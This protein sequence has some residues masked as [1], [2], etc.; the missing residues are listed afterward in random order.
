MTILPGTTEWP[1]NAVHV[2][3]SRI[4]SAVDADL[5]LFKR[6]LRTSDS[7]QSVGIFPLNKNDDLLSKE[8]PNREPTIKKYRIVIQ[9]IVQDTDEEACISVHTI[10]SQRLERM[11]YNDSPL[12]VGLTALSVAVDNTV[13]SYVKHDITLTRYLSNEISGTFIQTSW[14]EIELTTQTLRAG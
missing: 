14:I 11:L 1:N 6:P 7:T 5:A 13:E 10:L 8:M 2:I 12:L 4:L 3:H 9:T